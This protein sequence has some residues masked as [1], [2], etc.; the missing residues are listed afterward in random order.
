MER[1]PDMTISLTTLDRGTGIGD[2]GPVDNAGTARPDPEVPE[3]AH[4]RTFTAKYKL[5]VLAA[6]DA[7]ARRLE[8]AVSADVIGMPMGVDDQ[9]Q[10]RSMCAHPV[11]CLFGVADEAA[12]NQRRLTSGQ[13]EQV[14]VGERPLLPGH[15][16]P[17]SVRVTHDA[18]LLCEKCHGPARFTSQLGRP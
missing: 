14:R 16:R 15:P 13:Q 6:Y 12:V 8:H 3:R 1:F 18:P 9:R 17:Q 2:P 5:A 4:R 11:G 10:P 7:A